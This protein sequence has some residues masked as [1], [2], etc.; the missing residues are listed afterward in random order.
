[1]HLGGIA[2]RFQTREISGNLQAGRVFFQN[3]LV[4]PILDGSDSRSVSILGRYRETPPNRLLAVQ[5]CG[6]R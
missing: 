3:L 6:S 1:M 5:N 2:D 4:F